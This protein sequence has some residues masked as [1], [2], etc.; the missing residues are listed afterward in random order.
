M[1]KPQTNDANQVKNVNEIGEIAPLR[2][3]SDEQQDDGATVNTD[4]N[5]S[6]FDR[7]NFEAARSQVDKLNASTRTPMRHN[8]NALVIPS[9]HPMQ[10]LV[11][12]PGT[13]RNWRH[14]LF[15]TIRE[16]GDLS[17]CRKPC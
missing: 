4:L 6:L 10:Q 15:E 5:A 1:K 13:N 8:S 2:W 14:N 17:Q 16:E 3:T 12:N 7:A 9:P 11:S